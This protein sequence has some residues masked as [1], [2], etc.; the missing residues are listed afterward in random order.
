MGLVCPVPVTLARRFIL[1]PGW[2]HSARTGCRP[3][4]GAMK[5]NVEK[6][7]EK[8]VDENPPET[9]VEETRRGRGAAARA[10]LRALGRRT[11]GTWVL[12]VVALAALLV[13]GAGGAL[14]HAAVDDGGRHRRPDLADVR[15]HGP[16]RGDR[17]APGGPPPGAP[18]GTA[19]EEDVQP[20]AVPDGTSGDAT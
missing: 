17:D 8:D 3:S 7:V 20:D 9:P 5:E 18:E 19:P 1:T 4:L 13:G 2:E 16:D 12:V 11:V 14:V 15:E 6:N 10:R